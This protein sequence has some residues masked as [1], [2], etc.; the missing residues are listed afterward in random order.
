MI[1][2]ALVIAGTQMASGHRTMDTLLYLEGEFIDTATK[3]VVIKIVHMGTGN[4]VCNE[5]TPLSESNLQP[6]LNDI[7]KVIIKY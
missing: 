5:N 1:P 3:K 2:V 6:V 7:A 4:S